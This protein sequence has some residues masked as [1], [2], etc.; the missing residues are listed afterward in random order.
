MQE[1]M[2]KRLTDKQFDGITVCYILRGPKDRE[3]KLFDVAQR[4]G[5]TVES[6]SIPW[7]EAFANYPDEEMP[8]TFILG[9]RTKEGLTQAQLAKKIGVT[10]GHISEMERGKR[11]I[12]KAMARKLGEA[13]NINY[14]VFL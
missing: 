12:G 4:L 1:H 7:R 8:G 13:L 5:F 3:K 6:E 14:K 10:Q 2:K 11:T 9:A